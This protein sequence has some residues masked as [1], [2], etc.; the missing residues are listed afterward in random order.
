MSSDAF[1]GLM[2]HSSP[3]EYFPLK[4]ERSRVSS[5]DRAKP[6]TLNAYSSLLSDLEECH[7]YIHQQRHFCVHEDRIVLT[8]RDRNVA[9]RGRKD[10]SGGILFRATFLVPAGSPWQ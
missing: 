1:S 3:L 2:Q 10:R 7:F 4:D 8:F 5:I 9:P 6:R